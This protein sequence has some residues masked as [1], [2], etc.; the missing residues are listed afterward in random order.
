MKEIKQAIR[1]SGYLF[2]QRIVPLLERRGYKATPNHIFEDPETGEPREIDVHAISGEQIT[3]RDLDFVFPILLIACKNLSAP[4]VF[5]TQDEIPIM[6]L[7]GDVQVAGVP[8]GIEWHGDVVSVTDFLQVEKFHHYYRRRRLSSQFCCV[9]EREKGNQKRWVAVHDVENMGN[10]YQ[11]LVLPLVKCVEA[12]KR[13]LT[14]NFDPDPDDER[15]SIEF[16]FPII[17]TAGP[18]LECF[19]GKRQ[20]RYRRVHHVAFIRR[21]KSRLWTG[22]YRIDVVDQKGFRRLLDTIDN[23]VKK[24]AQRIKSRRKLLRENV[25]RIVKEKLEKARQSSVTAMKGDRQNI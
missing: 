1:R 2:E 15:I 24:L 22:D 5:F 7:A 8:D 17:L 13:D 23:D 4:L 10:L 12:E 25:R 18:L 11:N 6:E 19:V 16:Y 3:K 21:H 9:F 14:K 20:P